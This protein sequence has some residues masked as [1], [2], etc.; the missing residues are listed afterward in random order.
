MLRCVARLEM[1]DGVE[2][3]ACCVWRLLRH[4]PSRYRPRC[5]RLLCSS[6]ERTCRGWRRAYVGVIVPPFSVQLL[7]AAAKSSASSL[8]L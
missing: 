1:C 5:G 2:Q 8:S 7:S 3:L 4:E 6:S